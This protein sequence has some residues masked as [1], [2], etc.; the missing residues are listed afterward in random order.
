MVSRAGCPSFL[1]DEDLAS[2][3]VGLSFK[4]HSTTLPSAIGYRFMACCLDMWEVKTINE[5]KL[6]VIAS[7]FYMICPIIS[8]SSICPRCYFI[9]I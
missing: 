4:F 8:S 1:E 5:E 7:K 6:F 9:A 2:K 3:S